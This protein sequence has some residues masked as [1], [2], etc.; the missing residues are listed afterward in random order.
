MNFAM[1]TKNSLNKTHAWRSKNRNFPKPL[2]AHYF[3]A[4]KVRTGM[5]RGRDGIG[6]SEI[7]LTEI[8]QF[9]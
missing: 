2:N 1:F 4:Q 5:L 3:P 8:D 9:A 7:T 6:V